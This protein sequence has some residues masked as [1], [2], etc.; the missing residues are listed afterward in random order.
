VRSEKLPWQES[1]LCGVGA[2]NGS[3]VKRNESP[4][5]LPFYQLPES[6]P[7]LILCYNR[8]IALVKYVISARLV[9]IFFSSERGLF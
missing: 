6:T 8:V 9:S 5:F 4:P 7:R 1:L 2:V 3:P